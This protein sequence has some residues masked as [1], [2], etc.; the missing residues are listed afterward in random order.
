[1]S[2]LRGLKQHADDEVPK[3]NTLFGVSVLCRACA[4]MSAKTERTLLYPS[5]VDKPHFGSWSVAA[6]QHVAASLE[7]G[8]PILLAEENLE[9]GHPTVNKATLQPH[10]MACG[11]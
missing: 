11:S 9:V 6:E 3:Q 7:C 1:M 4:E 8:H 5:A 2:T 10:H